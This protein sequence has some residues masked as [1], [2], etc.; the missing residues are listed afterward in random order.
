[1]SYVDELE[2]LIRLEQ[3]LRQTIALSLAEERGQPHG[4]APTEEQL[5]VADEAI[6]AWAEEVDFEQDM[7]A[8]R[9]LTPLQTLLAEHLGICERIFDIRDRRLS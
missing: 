7:R 4:G 6:A 5:L 2:P 9:P 1:M 8:F 3:E